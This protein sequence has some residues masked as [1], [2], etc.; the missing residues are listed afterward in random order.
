[1]LALG[2]LT[3]HLGFMLG[4]GCQSHRLHCPTV[5]RGN[6]LQFISSIGSVR[7]YIWNICNPCQLTDKIYTTQYLNARH[8]YLLTRIR[9]NCLS[10]LTGRF[11]Y[12]LSCDSDLRPARM[13]NLLEWNWAIT[14]LYFLISGRPIHC[15]VVKRAYNHL[16]SVV[17][18]I[19]QGLRLRVYESE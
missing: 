18:H 14:L 19:S 2:S 5:V 3:N 15:F 16:G 9:L 4:R 7:S 8:N 1:M 17:A 13:K 10:Y 6:W 11:F 12:T